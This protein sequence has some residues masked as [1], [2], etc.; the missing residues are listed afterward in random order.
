MVAYQ[1]PHYRNFESLVDANV[2]SFIE[3]F[4]LEQVQ[5]LQSTFRVL[6][7]PLARRIAGTVLEYDARIACEGLASASRWML[8]EFQTELRIYN[9]ER[10]PNRGPLL[11]VANHPGMSDAMALFA[12]LP[13][14]DI[15]IV[16]KKNAILPLLQGIGQHIIFVPDSSLSPISTVRAVTK[17]LRAGCT[18]ILYP[19][20]AI[21]PDPATRSNAV[22]TL[23][24]WSH[25]LKVF[26]QRVPGLQVLPVC[27][28]GVISH[29][30]LRH[31]ITQLYR[32]QERRD[33]VAATL[34]VLLKQ[35][36]STCVSVR[37]G[38]PIQ[39]QSE[40]VMEQVHNQMIG[41]IQAD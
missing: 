39:A 36:R 21:E 38:K 32:T 30:V 18:V 25:S 10:I 41:L 13:R 4:R 11:V 12:S 35:Y 8:D 37:Y 20:G 28:S 24:R 2:Q 14:Q 29:S 22:D 3:A 1:T 5:P 27:V 15:K 34:M 6:I 19:A 7:Q 17:Q 9:I 23:P 40:T 26:A 33:W 31:P 16:A